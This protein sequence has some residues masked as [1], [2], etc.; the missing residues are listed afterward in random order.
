MAYVIKKEDKIIRA[1]NKFP[2][3]L[4]LNENEEIIDIETNLSFPLDWYNIHSRPEYVEFISH[5][6]INLKAGEFNKSIIYK[7]EQSWVGDKLNLTITA[8][9]SNHIV[10][11]KDYND[12]DSEELKNVEIVDIAESLD[13]QYNE[14]LSI[15]VNEN[16]YNITFKNGIAKLTNVKYDKHVLRALQI[17]INDV[18]IFVNLNFPQNL[19][20]LNQ[21]RQERNVKL[22]DCDP[23]FM[24]H[25]SQKQMTNVT[26]TL[27][28]TEFEK[29]LSYMQDLRD[30]PN[31]VDL[32]NIEWPIK[33]NFI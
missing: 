10:I 17:K 1:L 22:E 23:I 11:D 12:I 2:I 14:T 28:D 18:D 4:K 24:R 6:K 9:T 8:Y 30:F 13:T 31:V 29:L 25:I 26:S 21:I 16:S 20:M 15:T 7:T 3:P 5:D 32:E 33:P 27:T 19:I